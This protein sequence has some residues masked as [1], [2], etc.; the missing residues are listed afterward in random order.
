MILIRKPVKQEVYDGT[1]IRPRMA[2]RLSLLMWLKRRSIWECLGIRV[3]TYSITTL[4]STNTESQL[5]GSLLTTVT[6]VK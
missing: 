5:T 2:I 3:L 6:C 1:F 4:N